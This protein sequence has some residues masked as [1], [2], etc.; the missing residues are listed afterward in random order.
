ML[1]FPNVNFTDNGLVPTGITVDGSGNAVTKVAGVTADSPLSQWVAGVIAATDFNVGYWKSPSN[2]EIEGVLGPDVAMYV[3][4][5]DPN[6]DPNNL[7]AAGIL[8]VYNSFG[9]GIR[10]WGNRSAAFPTNTDPAQFIAIRRTADI[11]ED[12]AIQSMLQFIDQPLT[13]ALIDAIVESVNAFIRSLIQRGGLVDGKCSFNAAENPT[14][15]LAAGQLVLDI[16]M[17]PPPPLERLTFNVFLDQSL[18]SAL[19]QQQAA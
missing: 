16:D 11:I 19:Q 12:S 8:T 10:V 9:T 3:N 1:C 13:A 4:P 7:N 14:T 15:Q 2:I 18:L 5:S 6:S 17:M